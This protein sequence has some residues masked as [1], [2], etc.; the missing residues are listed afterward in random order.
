MMPGAPYVEPAEAAS[1]TWAS[2][3][4]AASSA[5]LESSQAAPT[6][7]LMAGHP[8]GGKSTLAGAIGRELGW[9][10]LDKDTLKST[11]MSATYTLS[12]H[13]VSMQGDDRNALAYELLFAIAHDLLVQQ[14]L[15]IIL[16]SPAARPEA[17][18]RATELAHAAD[19]QLKV[20]LCLAD[21]SMRNQRLASRVA[22]PSQVRV[23]KLDTGVDQFA[24]LPD[25]T[26][27]LQTNRPLAGLV[28]EAL[29][30][31]QPSVDRTT[32][33]PG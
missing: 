9:P 2:R 18:Q 13:G 21:L 15:S 31:L 5:R 7:V 8:G 26:L 11:L 24:H 25:D 28:E 3:A 27:A 6:L 17:M 23:H 4:M 30:Y 22:K 29:R 10:V 16:D 12:E 1:T 20:I 32:A 14:G 19:A 33:N